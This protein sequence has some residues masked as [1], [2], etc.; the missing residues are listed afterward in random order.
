MN[1]KTATLR[2]TTISGLLVVGAFVYAYFAGNPTFYIIGA[3]ALGPILVSAV[4]L[5]YATRSKK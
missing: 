1:R 2:T 5:F 3:V 4:K